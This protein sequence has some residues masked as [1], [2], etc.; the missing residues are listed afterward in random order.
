MNPSRSSGARFRSSRITLNAGWPVIREPVLDMIEVSERTS[1]GRR[2][3]SVWEIIPPIEAPTRW[4]GPSSSASIRPAA[5]SA[6]SSSRYCSA[7][8]RRATIWP[9][10][11]G[12]KSKSVEW[13]VS[14]LS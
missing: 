2:A 11:G 3:A 6:M 5:S 14:R 13:P 4:T 1:S 9:S 7:G 12:R 8:K 10:D